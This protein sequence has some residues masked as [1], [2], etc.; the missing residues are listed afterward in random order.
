LGD[1]LRGCARQLAE[2]ALDGEA[3]ELGDVAVSVG[4]AAQRKR[5]VELREIG[6]A[7]V[8]RGELELLLVA[9]VV[10]VELLVELRDEAVGP[11]AE[12]VEVGT[13]E[14]RGC[15]RQSRRRITTCG[16]STYRPTARPSWS[17]SPARSS[18]RSTGRTAPPPR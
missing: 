11:V 7:L 9:R 1:L 10:E 13:A 3:P 17:R 15:A 8:D 2:V 5:L 18:P 14:R 6:E 4:R 12:A 16:K